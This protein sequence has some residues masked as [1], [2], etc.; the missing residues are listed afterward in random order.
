[1]PGKVSQA[2]DGLIALHPDTMTI[3]NKIGVIRN[4]LLIPFFISD[5]LLIVNTSTQWQP[6]I[7]QPWIQEN[8]RLFGSV[9]RDDFRPDS[10]IDV[11]VVFDPSAR[12][13][14]RTL[15]RMKRELS[16]ILHRPV[17]LVPQDGL[18]PAIREAVLSSAQ[19]L[20]AA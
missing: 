1:M 19:E 6:F 16:G 10:D 20:H 9:L 7:N 13:T 2:G 11:F 5:Y 3:R 14:F 17:D 18:K 4:P 8:G 12:I 15:G